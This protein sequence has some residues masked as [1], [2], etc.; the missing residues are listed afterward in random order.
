MA[1]SDAAREASALAR[2][3]HAQMHQDPP[4]KYAV[5]TNPTH[6][7]RKILSLHSNVYA[8]HKAHL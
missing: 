6:G 1:W 4:T 5:I 8:A 7:P 3:A 2:H